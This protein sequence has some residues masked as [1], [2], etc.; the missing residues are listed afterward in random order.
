[1]HICT[2]YT[3]VCRGVYNAALAQSVERTALNRVVAGSSPAGGAIYFCRPSLLRC[4]SDLT[5]AHCDLLY[6]RLGHYFHRCLGT[7][8]VV[9][10]V[11]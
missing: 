8:V 2:E 9:P 4:S 7:H 1:M 6:V 10:G 5:T 11:D 3:Y